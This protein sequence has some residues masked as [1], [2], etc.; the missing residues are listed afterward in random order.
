MPR[1][2][3]SHSIEFKRQIV[4]EYHAG[5]VALQQKIAVVERVVVPRVVVEDGA[6]EAHVGDDL[7][8]RFALRT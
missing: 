6:V 7:P 4:A 2:H 8:A 3:H 5:G 1:R